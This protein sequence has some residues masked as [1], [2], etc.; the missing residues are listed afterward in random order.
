M[1]RGKKTSLRHNGADL[2]FALTAAVPT[3]LTLQLCLPQRLPV[4]V[5]VES[6]IVIKC[7]RSSVSCYT[8]LTIAECEGCLQL[9]HTRQK[10][11]RQHSQVR[12]RRSSFFSRR[13]GHTLEHTAGGC[14][15]IHFT[16]GLPPASEDIPVSQIIS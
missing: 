10:T 13:R 8:E 6:S 11:S 16:S 14:S 7:C 4:I 1:Q 12:N 15:V 2:P 9:F 5:L 3:T